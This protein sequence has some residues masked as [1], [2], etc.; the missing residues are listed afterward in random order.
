MSSESAELVQRFYES[1]STRDLD[2]VLESAHAEF[3]LD[4]TNSRSPFSGIYRGHEGLVRYWTDT[5]EAW[6]EFKL[7]IEDLIELG[8]GRLIAA[9]V[10]RGRGK[11]SGIEFEARGAILWTLRDGKILAGKFFQ[12]SAEALEAAATT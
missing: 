4:W 6:D 3:E 9:T 8:G 5:W 1:W 11:G 7:E 12:T 10:V 2:G